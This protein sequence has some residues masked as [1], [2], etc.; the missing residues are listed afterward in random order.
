M[1]LAIYDGKAGRQQGS[2][3]QA[4]SLH[5]YHSNLDHTIVRKTLSKRDCGD[6]LQAMLALREARPAIASGH[7]LLGFT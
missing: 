5:S 1:R 6:D 4:L 2:V 7:S 3:Y